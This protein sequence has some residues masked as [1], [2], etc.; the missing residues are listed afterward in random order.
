[1]AFIDRRTAIQQIIDLLTKRLGEGDT[2]EKTFEHL[3]KLYEKLD[4]QASYKK[5]GDEE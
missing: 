4:R 2:G 5:G 1:M 3:K